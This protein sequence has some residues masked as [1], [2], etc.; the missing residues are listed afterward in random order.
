[1]D[2]MAWSVNEIETLEKVQN[3][4][5]RMAL[6]ANKYVGVEA[7]RGDMGWSTFAERSMKAVLMYKIRLERMNENRWAKKVHRWNNRASKWE[8]GCKR[9]VTQCGLRPLTQVALDGNVDSW[10]IADERGVGKFWTCKRWKNVINGRVM[11]LGARKWK[12]KMGE[13]VT[14]AWYASKERPRHEKFYDGGLGGQLLFKARSQSLELNARTYRWSANG[15]KECDQC[16]TEEHET[17][18]HAVLRCAKYDRERSDLM[19]VVN[20]ATERGVWEERMREDD[21][22]MKF[23]LGLDNEVPESVIV[24]VKVF[25]ERMWM[26][27]RVNVQ[28]VGP[29]AVRADP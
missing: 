5:G 22:G 19:N 20:E 3:R 4:V 16:T 14:L 26:K 17:V 8:K 23:L 1:M 25:L 12:Q 18:E 6:G 28:Q 15:R 7:I 29:A 27:R 11:K 13:K 2:V 9:K 24:A 10:M 21:N